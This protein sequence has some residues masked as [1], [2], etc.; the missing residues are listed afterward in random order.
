MYRYRE[1]RISIL[2]MD[3]SQL[4]ARIAQS[5][6]DVV[7]NGRAESESLYILETN[8]K[9][10]LECSEWLQTD[11][12]VTT[13]CFEIEDYQTFRPARSS[14]V[15][16]ICEKQIRY[17][18]TINLLSCNSVKICKMAPIKIGPAT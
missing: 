10:C 13:F 15:P 1:L 17:S 11:G 16:A 5:P 12:G 18:P 4:Q 14:P 3:L 9:I 6:S 2:V 8:R 7:R